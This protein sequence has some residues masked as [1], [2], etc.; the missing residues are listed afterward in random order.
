[1]FTAPSKGSGSAVA[2]HCA[3]FRNRALR[4]LRLWKTAF[5]CKAAPNVPLPG[6]SPGRAPCLFLHG[7]AV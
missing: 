6:F 2:T 3:V 5:C 1:M 4:P 7:S